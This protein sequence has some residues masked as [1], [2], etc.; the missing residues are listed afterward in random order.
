VTIGTLD[1]EAKGECFM[2]LILLGEATGVEPG[3][4]AVVSVVPLD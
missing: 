3:V 2:R 1:F 4:V